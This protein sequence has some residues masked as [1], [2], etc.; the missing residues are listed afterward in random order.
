MRRPVH[1][2]VKLFGVG[3]AQLVLHVGFVPD[4]H[5]VVVPRPLEGDHEE[6]KDHQGSFL[7]KVVFYPNLFT[8]KRNVFFTMNEYDLYFKQ[9]SLPCQADWGSD[10]YSPGEEMFSK[11]KLLNL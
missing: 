5:R 6:P 9:P 2:V 11:S 7:H 1:L 10:S 8:H 4:S 3:Q